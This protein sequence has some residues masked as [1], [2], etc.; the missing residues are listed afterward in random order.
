MR[1][2]WLVLCLMVSFLVCGSCKFVLAASAWDDNFDDNS[3][4]TSLWQHIYIDADPATFKEQN[5]R[6]EWYVNGSKMTAGQYITDKYVSSWQFD[7]SSDMV[8]QV[9]FLHQVSAG[10]GTGLNLG[11]YY[12]DMSSTPDFQ[13]T[14]GVK[15]TVDSTI[16]NGAKI[17]TY[18][19]AVSGVDI[20]GGSGW[21]PRTDLLIFSSF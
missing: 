2:H 6:L 1:K 10:N 14:I 8:F 20:A 5:S 13:A 21:L 17:L 7:L 19:W 3:I 18:N 4:N 12:G 9:D 16:N 11:V 15:N